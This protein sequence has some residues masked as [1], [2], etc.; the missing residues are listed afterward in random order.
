MKLPGKMRSGG[1]D[2][3]FPPPGWDAPRGQMT[4]KS[5]NTAK[6]VENNDY[7]PMRRGENGIFRAEMSRGK[8][9]ENVSPLLTNAGACGMIW[10]KGTERLVRAFGGFVCRMCSRRNR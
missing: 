10:R 4:G 3:R 8:E 1:G 7:K 2:H 6:M 5:G 9:T